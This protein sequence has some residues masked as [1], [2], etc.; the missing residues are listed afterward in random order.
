MTIFEKLGHVT[1]GYKY[2]TINGDM[3]IFEKLGHITLGYNY[4]TINWRH[5]NF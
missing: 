3:T 2:T 4:T 1:L 5:D